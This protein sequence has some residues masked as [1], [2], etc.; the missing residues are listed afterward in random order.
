MAS[1]LLTAHSG[2][3]GTPPN[4][5]AHI[6]A[7]LASGVNFLE[8]DLRL[9][10]G[11][12]LVLSHDQVAGPGPGPL[13]LAAVWNRAADAGVGFNLDVKEREVLEPLAR[14]L[15]DRRGGPQP[16]ITGCDGVWASAWR[17]LV[18]GVPVLFNVQTGP[19]PGES[20]TH[21]EERLIREARDCGAA[22]LNADHRLVTDRLVALAREAGLPLDVWTVNE[23]EDLERCLGW[24]VAGITTD[25]PDRAHTLLTRI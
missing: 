3:L 6:D 14:F 25:R 4:S 12:D 22:G 17:G 10:P 8:V 19:R 15:R 20:S 2:C 9:G 11:G 16:V 1:P 23:T 7:A 21:W 24:G 18:P 13:T 5:F